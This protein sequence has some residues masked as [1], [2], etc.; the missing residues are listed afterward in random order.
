MHTSRVGRKV[1]RAAASLAK[2]EPGG[3]SRLF[4]RLLEFKVSQ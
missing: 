2:R 1:F 4:Y 3:S